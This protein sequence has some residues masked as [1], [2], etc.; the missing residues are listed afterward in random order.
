MRE[1]GALDLL[2]G[3]AAAGAAHDALRRLSGIG[4]GSEPAAAA[5]CFA[6]M[7]AAD[8]SGSAPLPLT[9]AG[10]LGSPPLPSLSSSAMVCLLARMIA[11]QRSPTNSALLSLAAS[12]TT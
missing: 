12:Q 1:Y 3:R 5:A 7:A 4:P 2:F 6:F 10:A 11:S 8:A 9:S